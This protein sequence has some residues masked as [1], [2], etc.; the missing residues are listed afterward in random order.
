MTNMNLKLYTGITFLF[1]LSL[2]FLHVPGVYANDAGKGHIKGIVT[3]SEGKPAAHVSVALTGTSIKTVSADEGV[4][5]HRD[6][7]GCNY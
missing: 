2:F 3:T 4:F 7:T 6:I 5:I 1:I